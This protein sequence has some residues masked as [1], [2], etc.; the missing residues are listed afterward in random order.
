MIK[1]VITSLIVYTAFQNIENKKK[2]KIFVWFYRFLSILAVMH[3]FK[4]K[5]GLILINVHQLFE[6]K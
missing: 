6:D 1:T 3:L 4:N 5:N 2:T